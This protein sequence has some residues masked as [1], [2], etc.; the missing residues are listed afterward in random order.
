MKVMAPVVE[1]TGEVKMVVKKA[2]ADGTA[3]VVLF[4][5]VTPYQ[6]K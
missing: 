1:K 4:T 6:L 3:P 2:N 5:R